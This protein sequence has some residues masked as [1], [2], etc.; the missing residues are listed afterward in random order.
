MK[1]KIG[2]AL[3]LVYVGF[4][5]FSQDTLKTNPFITNN[6]A[7]I[8]INKSNRF[9]NEATTI[10]FDNGKVTDVT[11]K[12]YSNNSDLPIAQ[13]ALSCIKY[14]KERNYSLISSTVSTIGG[15]YNYYSTY[16]YQYIFERKEK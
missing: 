2:L 12:I 4:E 13:K 8:E 7:I 15:A 11:D 6:F 14:M 16:D 1:N 3:L 5:A 9:N 10:H